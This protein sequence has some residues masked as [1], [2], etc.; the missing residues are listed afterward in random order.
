M[1]LRFLPSWAP[2]RDAGYTEMQ[3][4]SLWIWRNVLLSVTFWLFG[5]DCMPPNYIQLDSKM[6]RAGVI[7]TSKWELTEGKEQMKSGDQVAQAKVIPGGQCLRAARSKTHI[8]F[9]RLE[10]REIHELQPAW[11]TLLVILWLLCWLTSK[12]SVIMPRL[13]PFSCIWFSGVKMKLCPHPSHWI[14]IH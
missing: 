3:L 13:F 1:H 4:G 14:F 5:N 8:L 10:R 6:P 2:V 7:E 9:S 12:I 11:R